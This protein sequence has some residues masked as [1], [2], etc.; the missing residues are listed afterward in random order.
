MARREHQFEKGRAVLHQH[1]D[2]IAGADAAR[3]EPAADLPDTRV[4]ALR[5][6]YPRRGIS[7]H[8]GP[9]SAGRE[10]R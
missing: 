4:E 2:D 3:G 10:R 7:A 8:S 9:A 6:K 5:R 1:R